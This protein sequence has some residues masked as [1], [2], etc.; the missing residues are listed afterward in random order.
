[1]PELSL[2]QLADMLAMAAKKVQVGGVYRHYKGQTY[3][4]IGLAILADTDVPAVIY[5][6]DYDQR[7]SFVHS[8]DAWLKMVDVDGRS[9]PRFTLLP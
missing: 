7:L 6:P 4:V 3:T 8:L 9:V 5:R 1:M 2:D